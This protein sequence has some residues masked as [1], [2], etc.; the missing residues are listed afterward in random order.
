MFRIAVFGQKLECQWSI[1]LQLGR[2]ALSSLIS[3]NSV[4]YLRK[5]I[6]PVAVKS[7]YKICCKK[8]LNLK[9]KKVSNPIHLIGSFPRWIKQIIKLEY[10]IETISRIFFVCSKLSLFILDKITKRSG[11]KRQWSP[12]DF[13]SHEVTFCDN[14]YLLTPHATLPQTMNHFKSSE[15]FDQAAQVS[16]HEKIIKGCFSPVSK[17]LQN[18]IFVE[19]NVRFSTNPG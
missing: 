19:E 5:H 8:N 18:M 7:K 3:C 9:V 14:G 11:R 16:R 17:M 12:N 2:S 13:F 4:N 15:S 10:F 1:N 6:L